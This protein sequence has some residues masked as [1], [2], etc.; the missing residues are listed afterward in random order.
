V[1]LCFTRS[2]MTALLPRGDESAMNFEALGAFFREV[3]VFRRIFA[4]WEVTSQSMLVPVNRDRTSC[5]GPM[6]LAYGAAI[7]RPACRIAVQRWRVH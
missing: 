3:F 1:L 7:I 5:I 2:L 6:G 4:G